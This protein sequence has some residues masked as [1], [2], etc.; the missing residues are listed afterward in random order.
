[1]R[2]Y[3]RASKRCFASSSAAT[4]DSRETVGNPSRKSSSVSPPSRQSKSVWMGTRV[5]RNTGVPPRMSG[6]LMMT[7]M[8]RL[9]HARLYR[10]R[11]D[12]FG[13]P[14]RKEEEEIGLLRSE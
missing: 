2:I 3:G 9:Y 4:A 13:S 1:M 6:F 12:K 10:A 11:G 5:P 14:E 7:P 8:K